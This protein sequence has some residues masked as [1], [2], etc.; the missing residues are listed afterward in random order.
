VTVLDTHRTPEKIRWTVDVTGDRPIRGVTVG[1]NWHPSWK[2][3]ADGKPVETRPTTGRHI[4]ISVPTGT[5]DL[6]LEFERRP[7][8]KAYDLLSA[9]T[10]LGVAFAWYRTRRR[11]AS[12]PI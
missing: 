8:E 4:G 3:Y 11:R 1:M 10:L 12:S 5:R 6:T 2:A 7:R 9:V